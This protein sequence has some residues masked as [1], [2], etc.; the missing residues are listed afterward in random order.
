MGNFLCLRAPGVGIIDRQVRQKLQ[1]SGGMPGV[2]GIVTDK[3]E[4]CIIVSITKC[5][6]VIGSPRAY[7]IRNWRVITWLCNHVVV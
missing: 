7:L 5:S 3:I 1:I 4:P 6:I 2:G